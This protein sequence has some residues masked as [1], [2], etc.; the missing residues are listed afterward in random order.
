MAR[1]GL[2]PAPVLALGL[3]VTVAVYLPG[4]GGGFVFD[5][6]QNV[7]SNE[8]LRVDGLDIEALGQA[9]LSSGAGP[10]RRPL[11]MASFALN[12]HLL[13]PGPFGFKLVNLVIHLVNGMG[14]YLLALLL[15]RGLGVRIR[16][17]AGL[18]AAGCALLWLLHPLNL[19]GVLYVVQRM[20]S[21]SAMFLITGL[22]AYCAGRLRMLEGRP[23]GMVL[24]L[25]GLLGGGGLAL[26]AKE[27]GALMPLLAAVL[28]AGVF[29]LR[30]ACPSG[31]LAIG[32]LTAVAVPAVAVPVVL[33]V[34][35]DT[36]L[37]GYRWR[38]FT[39]PERM[40]TE[41][42]AL[43]LYL[44]Q[45]G[46]PDPQRMALYHDDFAISMGLL[47]PPTTLPAVLGL[48]LLAS[49]GLVAL[50]RAPAAGVGLL[51]FLAGHSL[52]ST[53][54]P[55]E[56]VFEHR[57]YL[58][59]FGL[60]FAASFYGLRAK[61]SGATRLALGVVFWGF[62]GIC[63]LGTLA[64]AV[65][66]SSLDRQILSE[67]ARK[68]ASSRARHDAGL[69]YAALMERDPERADEHY[70]KARDHLL[71]A[72]EAPLPS[73][74]SLVVL[75]RLTGERQGQVEAAWVDRAVALLAAAPLTLRKLKA[76]ANL[77]QC[78]LEGHCPV[79][80]AGLLHLAEDMLALAGPDAGK[81][82]GRLLELASLLSHQA[83]EDPGRALELARAAVA[84][85]PSSV[86]LRL[87]LAFLLLDAGDPQG[88]RL[89]LAQGVA[90]DRF[91]LESRRIE[92]LRRLL[93]QQPGKET[94]AQEPPLNQLRSRL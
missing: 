52:E 73:A 74:L 80:A 37:A 79:E 71:A 9:A 45:A 12:R 8:H 3:M 58:P 64:R 84:A 81:A 28:E 4:L 18:I 7:R 89:E 10:L 61:G 11:S 30:A 77:V 48:G 54:L 46:F 31:R 57:N 44:S 20:T 33:L 36:L 78:S 22:I 6:L 53:F 90:L 94:G 65:D 86:R 47:A 23:G 38:W 26:L 55:L 88:A 40:L 51:F 29:R 56:P 91:R 41:A 42:R 50:K 93:D 1:P 72:A 69:L 13:G 16:D 19:T 43:W 87:N 34:A 24:V 76:Y 60:A 70:V 35:P 2:P 32:A 17:E 68:P 63:A 92:A 49:L 59:L 85:H 14:V 5:D 27:T 83:L 67:V 82:R 75:I 66:W 15:L 21:L 39:L 62:L 25:T